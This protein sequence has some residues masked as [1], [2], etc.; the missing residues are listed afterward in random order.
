MRISGCSAKMYARVSG[1]D[2]F[3]SIAIN[4]CMPRSVLM[5]S[6]SSSS[7]KY[8]SYILSIG[9]SGLATQKQKLQKE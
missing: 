9:V 4:P 7:F 3:G 1:F 8:L 6:L 5:N 2:S